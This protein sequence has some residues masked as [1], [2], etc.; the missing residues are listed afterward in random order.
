MKLISTLHEKLGD[1]WWYTILLFIA[2]R[3]GDV[4]NMFIGLWLVPKYV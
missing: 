1:L 3:M 4:I 2:Q